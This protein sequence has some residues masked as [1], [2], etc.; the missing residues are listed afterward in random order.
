MTRWKR[1]VWT[2]VAAGVAFVPGG[3]VTAAIVVN[4]IHPPP[5]IY[6]IT[7]P[8]HVPPTPG[9]VS[10]RFAMVHD[11]LHERFP[12]HGAEYYR[13]RERLARR[14]LAQIAPDSDE[15]FELIDDIGVGLERLGRPADAIPILRDKLQRQL[16][17]GM[18]GRS[19]YTTYA[20][21]GTFL[22]HANMPKAVAG[23]KQAREAVNE[24]L[25]LVRKSI[26]VNPEAHFGRE[27]WQVVLAE[28]LLNA[29]DHPEILAR[30]DFI[31][32]D[33]TQSWKSQR[34]DPMRRIYEL[35]DDFGRPVDASF[36]KYRHFDLLHRNLERW[37][38]AD[39]GSI[40]YG[41]LNDGRDCITRVGKRPALLPST[42]QFPYK[43]G[44][45]FDEPMLGI[46]GMW[47]QGGGANP[48][49]SLCIGETMLRVG[50]R[51]I[52]WAAFE[53]TKLLAG[54]SWPKPE[55]QRSIMAHCD[56][57]QRE[58]EETL[59]ADEVATLRSDFNDELSFGLKYQ[60]DYQAYEAV[61]IAAGADIAGDHFFDDF[62]ARH[63][64]I[65]SPTGLEELY[66]FEDGRIDAKMPYI[67][68]GA[69]LSSGIAAFLTSWFL[70]RRSRNRAMNLKDQS[71]PIGSSALPND[72]QSN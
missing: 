66:A 40:V 62:N 39:G 17:R 44:V 13:E 18:S 16:N 32:N 46:I 51:H 9:G 36:T 59:P 3:C 19:L 57:R 20:N 6:Y 43:E 24:G 41:V 35:A 58:I 29:I 48:H 49:F 64:A 63:P 25:A 5:R 7:L 15:A 22:A 31:G 50:Q 8:H 70:Y 61:K 47:R 34:S 72:A 1:L 71:G 33:L 28:F 11:V 14:R 68:G 37:E 67:V 65:Q 2:V 45:A 10:F 23:D 4:F 53:R 52:A 42:E 12:K 26:D 60:K 56:S 69:C 38:T 27:V 55:I 30:Q 54:R 21:L